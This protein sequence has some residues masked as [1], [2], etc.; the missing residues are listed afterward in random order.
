VTW[1]LEFVYLGSRPKQFTKTRNTN[2]N[3]S[4]EY[5]WYNPVWQRKLLSL[6]HTPCRLSFFVHFYTQPIRNVTITWSELLFRIWDV[7]NRFSAQ[8]PVFVLRT[9]CQHY[10]RGMAS[11]TFQLFHPW[12]NESSVPS[13]LGKTDTTVGQ[14]REVLAVTWYPPAAFWSAA[15]QEPL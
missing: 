10:I 11:L 5:A 12:D 7:P 8:K 3:I 6:Y 13:A 9:S 15:G 1:H 14:K 4:I 2:W